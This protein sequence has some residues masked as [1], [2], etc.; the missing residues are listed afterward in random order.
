MKR[1]VTLIL[2]AFVLV[3]SP[4]CDRDRGEPE[5][6]EK[7]IEQAEEQAAGA[8]DKIRDK[9]DDLVEQGGDAARERAS[10][11]DATEK[12]LADLDRRIQELRAHVQTR[13]NQLAG[14][15]KRD[16]SRELAELEATRNEA[17]SALDRFRTQTGAE[18]AQI[19]QV[20]EEAM[21]KLRRAV[22]QADERLDSDSENQPTPTHSPNAGP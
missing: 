18:M 20:T 12:E 13:S 8:A 22:K 1:P 5:A 17:R 16:L 19:Q 3:P 9:R 14:Q 15:S 10:F 4:A 11:L 2:S 7:V 6:T 21:T